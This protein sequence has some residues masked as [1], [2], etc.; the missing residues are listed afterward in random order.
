MCII[1]FGTLDNTFS[2]YNACSDWHHAVFLLPTKRRVSGPLDCSPL[3]KFFCGTSTL[4]LVRGQFA[5]CVFALHAA[6]RSSAA[7]LQAPHHQP[8]NQWLLGCR[9]LWLR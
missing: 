1:Y 2:F 3:I 9:C 4:M 5:T 8:P 6:V 7:C